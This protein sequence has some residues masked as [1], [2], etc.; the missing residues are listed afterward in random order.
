MKK[1]TYRFEIKLTKKFHGMS[2]KPATPK[3]GVG[4]VLRDRNQKILL[5]LRKGAHGA[6]QWSLPGGHMELGEDFLDVCKREVME[7][8]GI[9]I[10]SI[11]QLTFTNDIF[12]KEGLHYVTL[13]FEAHWSRCENPVNMEPDKCAEMRWFTR[14]ELDMM[15]NLFAPLA[16]VIKSCI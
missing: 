2:A 1:R 8:T 9:A 6:G 4:V 15:P 13:F 14:D 16:K 5:M 11:N 10:S 12:E 3:I 7:E